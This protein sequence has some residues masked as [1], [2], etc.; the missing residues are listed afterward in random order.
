MKLYF[1]GLSKENNKIKG[2]IVSNSI[3]E[4]RKDLYLRGITVIEVS[5]TNKDNIIYDNKFYFSGINNK[6]E[7]IN[8]S[9]D[10]KDKE[11]ALKVLKNKYKVEVN[12]IIPQ[13]LDKRIVN[14]S[15]KK[16]LKKSFTQDM[17]LVLKYVLGVY[18]SY[19]FIGNLLISKNINI[20]FIKNSL[21]SPTLIY[22]I[23]GLFITN[24]SLHFAFSKSK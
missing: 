6:K 11:T 22:I 15:K 23:I 14:K 1:V 10:A 5:P 3:E 18:I 20:K 19:V 17:Y 13:Y 8:G 2:I 4:A 16:F 24:L 12:E 9:I 7:K 21:S